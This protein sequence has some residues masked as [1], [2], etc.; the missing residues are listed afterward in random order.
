[1]TGT[2]TISALK[3]VPSLDPG[4][5]IEVEPYAEPI[6]AVAEIQAEAEARA[7]ARFSIATPKEPASS[8]A[9]YSFAT[10]ARM[11]LQDQRMATRTALLTMP[12]ST[13]ADAVAGIDLVSELDGDGELTDHLL[14]SLRRYLLID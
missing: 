3:S 12:I 10:L 4:P 11:H 5:H 8:L 7:W 9:G 14:A 6:L 1:V 13:K 2:V